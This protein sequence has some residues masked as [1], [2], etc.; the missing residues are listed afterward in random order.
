[1]WGSMCEWKLEII[2]SVMARMEA[3]AP[4]HLL[5]DLCRSDEKILSVFEC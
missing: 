1:M 4:H 5:G 2:A 3:K